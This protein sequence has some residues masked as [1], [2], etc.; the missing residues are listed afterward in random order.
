[1]IISIKITGPERKRGETLNYKRNKDREG[2]ERS[3]G[4]RERMASDTSRNEMSGGEVRQ[5]TMKKKTLE[6]F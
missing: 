6:W 5:K 2:N 1:M 3:E 4:A